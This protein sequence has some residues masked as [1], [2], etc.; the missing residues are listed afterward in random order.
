MGVEYSDEFET[1]LLDL[2]DCTIHLAICDEQGQIDLAEQRYQEH[3]LDHLSNTYD[4]TAKELILHT[5]EL[6]RLWIN[7][8]EHRAE[9]YT[10][11]L[12]ELFRDSV[13]DDYSP[14]F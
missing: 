1:E 10:Q 13:C 8:D 14:V 11:T 12:R 5:N 6:Y 9:M 7:H 4:I 2:E 3:A